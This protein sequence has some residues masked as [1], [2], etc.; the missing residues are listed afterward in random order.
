M[1]SSLNGVGGAISICCFSSNIEITN[2]KFDFCR[3]M[4]SAKRICGGCIN[5]VGHSTSTII[6][7]VYAS[8]CLAGRGHFCDIYSDNLTNLTMVT[9]SKCSSLTEYTD[10]VTSYIYFDNIHKSCNIS[11]NYMREVMIWSYLRSE[12]KDC[13][14]ASNKLIEGESYISSSFLSLTSCFVYNNSYNSTNNI[15]TFKYDEFEL[16]NCY[17]LIEENYN[18]SNSIVSNS[19]INNI[20]LEEIH[21]LAISKNIG[22]NL[23]LIKYAAAFALWKIIVIVL[24]ILLLIAIIAVYFIVGQN[25]KYKRLEDRINLENVYNKDFG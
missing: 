6:R 16:H 20:T 1:T 12:F 10:A 14:I 23:S 22:C 13:V 24:S 3:S 25:R 18:F 11:N 9:I 19:S 5:I 4:S 2:C 21:K 15:I 17:L 8:D 7:N